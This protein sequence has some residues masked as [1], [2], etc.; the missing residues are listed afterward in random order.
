M[1][2]DRSAQPAYNAGPGLPQRLL[3]WIM[4][5][6][7]LVVAYC[8]LGLSLTEQLS[9]AEIMKRCVLVDPNR[10][11]IWSVGNVEIGLAY[12]G[13]FFGM[14][15]YFLRMYSRS[16]QH[17]WDLA[18]A[19]VYLVG[20]FALDYFCVQTFHPFMALL[21]GDAAVMTFTVMV[22]RQT[23]FQRLLG[24]FVPIIFLTCAVGHFLEGLSY[25]QLTYN[26]NTPWTMVTADVGFAVLVNA[27]RF[28]AFIRGEDVVAELAIVKTRAEELQ[29]EIDAR[30]EAEEARAKSEKLRLAAEAR[31]R[32]FLSDVLASV[33]EG[34][35]RLIDDASGLPPKLP[36]ACDP[37]LLT[38]SSDM[39]VLRDAA[40]QAALA[41]GFSDLRW[42][43][44]VTGV[45]EAAMNAIVHAGGGE[46]H[47]CADPDKTVQIWITDT[48]KGIAVDNLPR[49]TLERGWT[50][51]GSLGHGF[52]LMLQTIDRVYLLTGPS[53]TT[54]VLEQD[55]VAPLP[56]WATDDLRV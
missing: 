2:F 34:K 18:L 42:Q 7:V 49:A 55:S 37:I 1:T 33:T 24:V 32:T 46:S 21:V 40:K 5:V 9:H 45:S 56:A 48:G 14:V 8:L 41:R 52:W 13:V 4:P 39:R 51:A 16:R 29:I 30:K 50:T 23:W 11:R 28:P 20:S 47:V 27:S 53:G 17:L 26:V 38:I 12:F 22:S 35:L 44:L 43:N 31:M 10:A 25:W 6:F 54:L 15:F 3:P 19:L 36:A